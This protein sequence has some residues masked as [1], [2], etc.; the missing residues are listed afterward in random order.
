MTT[1]ERN[2]L[3]IQALRHVAASKGLCTSCAIRTAKP[4]H[5]LCDTYLQRLARSNQHANAGACGGN[6]AWKALG[7]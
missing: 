7:A 3:R 5:R 6:A 1:L 4:Q 2:R